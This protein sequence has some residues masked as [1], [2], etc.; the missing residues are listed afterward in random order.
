MQFVG[1]ISGALD[2][3]G[4]SQELI[5]IGLELGLQTLKDKSL[6]LAILY[7]LPP[8]VDPECGQDADNNHQQVS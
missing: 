8:C 1:G 2:Y 7:V 5:V 4:D 3:C 6:L